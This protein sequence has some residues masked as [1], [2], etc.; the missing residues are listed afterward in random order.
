MKRAESLLSVQDG[1]FSLKKKKNL[2]QYND[3][4]LH[5]HFSVVLV[6]WDVDWGTV[7]LEIQA[8]ALNNSVS[9]V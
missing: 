1:I 7:C 2:L 8:L 3:I 9:P 5:N 4:F 6:S